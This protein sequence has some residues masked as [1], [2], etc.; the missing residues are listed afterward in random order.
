M[1]SVPYIGLECEAIEVCC[2][3]QNFCPELY[4][5]V[6]LYKLHRCSSASVDCHGNDLWELRNDDGTAA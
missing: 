2:W 3:Q 4:N 1:D 5:S 6:A